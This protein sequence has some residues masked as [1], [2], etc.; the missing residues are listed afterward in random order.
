MDKSRLKT[1]LSILT[2]LVIAGLVFTAYY[3]QDNILLLRRY[4]YPGIFLI[5][6]IANASIFLPIP[7]SLIAVAVAP[8]FNPFA[9]ALVASLGAALGELSA[10]AFGYSSGE[11]IPHR[12]WQDQIKHWLDRYGG[13][14]IL[15]F[16]A[17]PNPLFDTAGLAAGALKMKMWHFFLWCWG[18]KFLNRLVLVFSSAALIPHLPFLK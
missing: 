17:V 18:G 13:I 12:E 11:L 9:L 6:A 7:G 16:A 14:T 15:V 10:Y 8:L 4:G 3:F 5:E 2:I 1:P